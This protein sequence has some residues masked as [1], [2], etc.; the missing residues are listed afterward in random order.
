[1]ALPSSAAQHVERVGDVGRDKLPVRVLDTA[2]GADQRR[3]LF[4]VVG[5]AADGPG[6]DRRVGGHPGDPVGDQAGEGAVV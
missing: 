3:E 5:G 2:A 6:E 4:V 1:M